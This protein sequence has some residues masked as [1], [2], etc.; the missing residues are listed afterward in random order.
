[1]PAGY[2]ANLEVMEL[3]HLRYFVAVAEALSFSRAAIRLHVTQPALSR[4]IRDLEEELGCRLLRRGLNTRT[5]LTPEGRQVLAGAQSLLAAAEKLVASVRKESARLRL[6]HY[7]S[8]WL[9]YFS[10]ALRR[11]AQEHPT[12]SLQLVELT[13]RELAG[14]LRRGEV[15]LALMGETD[16]ELRKEFRT[17]LVA[18]AP[19][20][21]ALSATHPL[22]KRRKLRLAEL[23]EVDWVTWDEKEFPWPKR[24]LVEACRKAGFKP[25]IVAE[26][27]S[28]SSLFLQ[29]A[30]SKAVGHVVRLAERLPHAGVVF[31]DIDPPTAMVSRIEVAWQRRDP[32]TKLIGALV[33][34][35]AVIHRGLNR[36]DSL[37]RQQNSKA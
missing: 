22:A 33:A 31:A 34:E 6:G 10:P 14:A 7:G 26:T 25:R 16:A 36:L 29:V 2:K 24:L 35:M 15:S 28:M 5:E 20:R 4:Q 13:P 3:R 21:L 12:V 37:P 9:D 8:L 17:R 18:A 23:R 30:T 19:S 11:F 1:M 32:R 27:D